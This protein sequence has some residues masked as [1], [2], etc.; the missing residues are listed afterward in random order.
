ML[1]TLKSSGK[2][3]REQKGIALEARESLSETP[4]LDQ[5]ASKIINQLE[6][7]A[8]ELI[9]GDSDDS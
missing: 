1:A 9:S 3:L 8:D 5:M 7:K 4:S 2:R 6:A